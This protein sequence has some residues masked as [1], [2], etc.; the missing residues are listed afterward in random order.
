M[1]SIPPTLEGW[2]YIIPIHV[3]L[4]RIMTSIPPT[5]EEWVYIIP[6]HETLDVSLY[7]GSIYSNTPPQ[8]ELPAQRCSRLDNKKANTFY[9]KLY[10]DMST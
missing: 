6:I 3:P 2:V 7:M 10:S 9:I 8:S 4:E 1:T 5:L